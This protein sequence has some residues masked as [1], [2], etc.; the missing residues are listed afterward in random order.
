MANELAVAAVE[1]NEETVHEVISLVENA[2]KSVITH[3]FAEKAKCEK[4]VDT[5]C[6]DNALQF[7]QELRKLGPK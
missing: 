5:K 2:A 7:E 4:D 1:E 6:R 3:W